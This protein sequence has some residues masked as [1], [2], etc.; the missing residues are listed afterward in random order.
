M[1]HTNCMSIFMD[2]CTAPLDT[3]KGG[4]RG[5]RHST[6]KHEWGQQL[7]STGLLHALQARA[8]R[9][10]LIKP[11]PLTHTPPIAEFEQFSESLAKSEDD[12]Y[13]GA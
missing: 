11:P 8:G 5:K 1:S 7:F 3:E 12:L 13:L 2:Y 10:V 6:D 4:R 9:V